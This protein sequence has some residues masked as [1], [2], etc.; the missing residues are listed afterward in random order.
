MP[1]SWLIAAIGFQVS[2]VEARPL[3]VEDGLLA[4]YRPLVGM[5]EKPIGS[6]RG[7]LIDKMNLG[8]GASLGDPWCAAVADWGQKKNGLPGKGAYSPSWYS[9]ARAVP[10]SRV[11]V[12]D[13]AL[14]WFPAKGRYAHTIACI[15]QVR[16]RDVVTLEGNTN[17]QGSREGHGFFRRVRPKDGLTYVRWR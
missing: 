10:V 16:A 9:K 13:I 1:P 17:S 11:Q 2:P 6:N 12:G 4:V 3:S 14:V 15:E 7:A 8:A 5:Q